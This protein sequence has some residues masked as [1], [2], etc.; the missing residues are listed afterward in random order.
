MD[1]STAWIVGLSGAA[2]GALWWLTKYENPIVSSQQPSIVVKGS[3]V[4]FE[5]A[6]GRLIALPNHFGIVHDVDGKQLSRCAIFFVPFRRTNQS[7]RM[8]A[9]AR[10]YL[11]SKYDAKLTAIDVP[12]GSWNSIVD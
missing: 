12:K 3:H 2:V 6:N 9:K 11:G 10:A 4:R 1:N 5:M 7:A 8:S